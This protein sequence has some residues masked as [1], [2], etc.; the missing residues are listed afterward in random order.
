MA[1]SKTVTRF[2]VILLYWL[3]GSRAAGDSE[4]SEKSRKKQHEYKNMAEISTGEEHFQTWQN[5]HLWAPF[6]KVVVTK[7]R[8]K[9][10]KITSR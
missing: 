6:Q 3:S 5:N 10:T 2:T 9:K 1:K 7:P 4:Q 8:T